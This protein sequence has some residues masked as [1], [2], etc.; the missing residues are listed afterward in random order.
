MCRMNS[1]Y[2]VALSCKACMACK[3]A[4][5]VQGGLRGVFSTLRVDE[6][7]VLQ[8]TISL[9]TS[10]GAGPE[11]GSTLHAM[12]PTKATVA[13]LLQVEHLLKK[14]LLTQ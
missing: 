2:R 4:A 6:Q 7:G 12:V 13:Q 14:C 10:E 8:V 3:S 1:L 11:Q 9:P 5:G